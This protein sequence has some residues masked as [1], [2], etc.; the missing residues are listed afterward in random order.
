MSVKTR[1]G[2]KT[3]TLIA[4]LETFGIDV[5]AFAEELKKL[6]AGSSTGKSVVSNIMS[7]CMKLLTDV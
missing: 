7:D 2:R 6:C 5:E 4:S 3:V 1:Q